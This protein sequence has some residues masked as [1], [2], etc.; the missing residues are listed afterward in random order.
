[1]APQPR[2]DLFRGHAFAFPHIADALCRCAFPS[3]SVMLQANKV[4]M[5]F[6]Q[7]TPA[8][9]REFLLQF[10]DTHYAKLTSLPGTGKPGDGWFAPWRSLVLMCPTQDGGFADSEVPGGEALRT[11]SRLAAQSRKRPFRQVQHDLLAHKLLN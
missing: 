5:N 9:A 10:K 7:V 3:P 11:P 8:Q 1:M 6:L 2:F 4:G